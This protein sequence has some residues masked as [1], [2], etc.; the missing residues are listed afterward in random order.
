MRDWVWFGVE[1]LRLLVMTVSSSSVAALYP[2]IE[3]FAWTRA[4][5]CYLTRSASRTS[6]DRAVQLAKPRDRTM[7]RRTRQRGTSGLTA[8]YRVDWMVQCV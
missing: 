5:Y 7:C 8:R 2:N 1:S 3:L 6:K 4:L